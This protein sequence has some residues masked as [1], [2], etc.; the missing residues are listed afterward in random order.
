MGLGLFNRFPFPDVIEFP[1]ALVVT[2]FVGH[3][4]VP[5][6]GCGMVHIY[7]TIYF[8][9]ILYISHDGHFKGVL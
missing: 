5:L 2:G 1:G 4:M 7:G 8:I 3:G 9:I 6:V